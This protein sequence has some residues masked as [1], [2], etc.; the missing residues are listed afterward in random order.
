MSRLP[1]YRAFAAACFITVATTGCS[2]NKYLS[3][4]GD[5]GKDGN[6]I[7][8]QN[9]PYEPP[10]EVARRLGNAPY[11]KLSEPAMYPSKTYGLTFK[12]RIYV[13]TQ[14]Q[15]G[16]P[17][18][19]MVFQDASSVYLGLMNTPLVLDNL[20]HSGEIPVTIALFLD[21]GTPTGEYVHE[22]DKELRSA[23]YDATDGKYAKFLTEEIIPKVVR[24]QYKIIADPSGW[25][26]AGQS[27]GGVAAF[28]AAWERP[29]FFHRVL[30]QNGSFVNIRG[31]GKYP[32]LVRTDPPKP[33]RVYLLSGTND[34]NN[35]FGSWLAA[36]QAM[37]SAFGEA[38][39]DYR[40]RTGTG[41]HFPPLQAQA[42]F[43]D[44][45]RWLWRGFS[46]GTKAD[47]IKSA[48]RR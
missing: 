5:P 28:T 38:D 47:L 23:Q 4:Q 29:D 2:G 16:Q 18:A 13:P 20:I 46:I 43:A 17:A 48:T 26:I 10:P 45:L 6:G 15:K 25:A 37:A 11:G 32:E 12:Y 14:Y 19:L 36:N 40:F 30:T 22:R 39:Y 7:E 33:L 42:D 24:K 9:G 1:T 35:Q 27:S 44:A 41:G 3:I 8:V 21:P 31:A 34:L